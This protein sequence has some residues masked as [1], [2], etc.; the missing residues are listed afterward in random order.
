MMS[1][2]ST[3]KPESSP[4]LLRSVLATLVVVLVSL[5]LG[6]VAAGA[7]SEVDDPAMLEQGEEVFLGSCA[8]CHGED[9][10]GTVAG[11]P[12]LGIADQEPDR[13]VHIASVVDGKGAMPGFG[14]FLAEEDVDA[15][16]SYVRL[17]F[18]A[19]RS[20][21][22]LPNTGMASELFLAAAALIAAGLIFTSTARRA[23]VL[24]S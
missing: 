18:V 3:I 6:A 2:R 21:D 12:L 23:T 17:T 20:V 16:V 22:E 14:D 1:H 4:A 8:G 5:G 19:E 7:Q 10:T 11:R 24:D 9:G 13:L 15:V